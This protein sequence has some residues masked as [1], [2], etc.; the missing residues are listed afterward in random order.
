MKA[1]SAKQK[2]IDIRTTIA[3][4]QLLLTKIGYD[5]ATQTLGTTMGLTSAAAVGAVCGL[6]APRSA[7]SKISALEKE[8]TAIQESLNKAV[9]QSPHVADEAARQ[10]DTTSGQNRDPGAVS[11]REGLFSVVSSVATSLIA[12]YLF[13]RFFSDQPADADIGFDIGNGA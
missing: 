2:E 5:R 3:R 8:V 7:K 12:R 13:A 11:A 6:L 1:L 4:S 10:Q 9:V